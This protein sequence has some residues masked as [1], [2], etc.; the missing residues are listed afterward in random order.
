MIFVF[1]PYLATFS[2]DLLGMK[3][4]S[5]HILV[6]KSNGDKVPFDKDKI[7]SALKYSG[8]G[9]EESYQILQQIE[10]KL[11]DGIPTRKIYQLAYSLLKKKKS[12]RTA[13]RYRLKKAI[14]D[15]GP[16][17]YAFELFVSRLFESWGHQVKTDQLIK[18][19]CILHEVDVL[20][21]KPG[22]ITFVECKFRSDYRGKT[23][24]KVPLYIHSRFND[25]EAKWRE[26]PEYE[27]TKIEGFI[28][29]NARF[30]KDA[31]N[32]AE[33]AGLG[34]ISW[35]YP[36]ESSLKYYVD[37]SGMHPIT[38]LHSLTKAH[39]TILLKEGVILC[40]ELVKREDA[41]QKLGLKDKQID[42]IIAEAR[43]LISD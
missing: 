43:L 21:T 5:D 39:K 23:D 13:G 9:K 24:V 10:S 25:I 8:A 4:R 32:Y 1:V 26:N 27:H 15:L 33:C 14:F 36:A 38:S 34:L 40:R 3:E 30:T 35:D 18:G 37:K 2:V 42:K 41:L 12:H 17:G 29:T 19:K 31:I 22:L 11:Y 20:A 28:V 7:L 6:L 16:S